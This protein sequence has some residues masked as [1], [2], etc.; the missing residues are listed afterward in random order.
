MET[1][2][3]TRENTL[4]LAVDR[5]IAAEPRFGTVLA[6]HGY[7]SLRRVEPGL[8]SLLRI[9]TDQLI[10]LK[11]GEAIWQRIET[12]LRQVSAQAV[13]A[14][15][16]GELKS[17]GLSTSKALTF[18][19][20]AAAS[21]SGLLESGLSELS[22]EQAVRAL[23]A[24]RGIGPWTADIYLLT[25]MGRPDAWPAG[26]LALQVAA[27]HLF[28]LG[29]RPDLKAMRDIAVSWS[30]YRSAAA[31]LLWSHYRGLKRMPQHPI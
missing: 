14:T 29:A 24:I 31:R 16:I 5:L 21:E 22:D 2:D 25:A 30:P 1:E 6:L 28:G 8:R 26:D 23:R 15:S 27:Q 17:L 19:A 18:H 7:P 4:A 12:R 9:V 10:S 3:P 11:A 13:L 20:A